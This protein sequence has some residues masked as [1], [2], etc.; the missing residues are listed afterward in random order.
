MA[1]NSPWTV[2]TFS[3]LGLFRH[4][5]IMRTFGGYS[6]SSAERLSWH[7]ATR[8]ELPHWLPGVWITNPRVLLDHRS[9]C[10]V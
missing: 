5:V 1:E 8:G 10:S 4:G 2:E 3:S 9:T 6:S 7:D